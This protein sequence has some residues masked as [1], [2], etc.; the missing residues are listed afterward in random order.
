MI[1]LFIHAMR[2]QLDYFGLLTLAGLLLVVYFSGVAI[3]ISRSQYFV[4]QE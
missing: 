2:I 1:K 3:I 4:I